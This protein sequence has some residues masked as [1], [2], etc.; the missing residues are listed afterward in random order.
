[1]MH[2]SFEFWTSWEGNNSLCCRLWGVGDCK[3]VLHLCLKLWIERVNTRISQSMSSLSRHIVQPFI[4]FSVVYLQLNH[5][6][7]GR[8]NQIMKRVR[9]GKRTLSLRP[10]HPTPTEIQMIGASL[11]LQLRSVSMK[12]KSTLC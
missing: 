11:P 6:F 12:L 8:K 1:M 5:T 3:R 4:L 7:Q 9:L 10:S 2:F